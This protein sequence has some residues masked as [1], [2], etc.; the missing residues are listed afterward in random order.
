VKQL[1]GQI[2]D[3]YVYAANLDIPGIESSV[4]FLAEGLNF[5]EKENELR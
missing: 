5:K 3:D 2:A 1:F 4:V